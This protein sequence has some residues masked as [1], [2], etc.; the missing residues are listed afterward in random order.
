MLKEEAKTFLKEDYIYMD[1]ILDHESFVSNEIAF[2]GSSEQSVELDYIL[3]D[4]LPDIFRILKCSFYPKVISHSLNGE[5]LIFDLTLCIKILYLSNDSTCIN[6]IEQKQNYTK[7]VDLSCTPESP[8]FKITPC[9]DYVNCRVVNSRR[10]DIRGAVTTKIILESEKSTDIISSAKGLNVQ[11]KKEFVTF[12][13]KRLT[14]A[15]RITITEEIEL[16][17]TKGKINSVIK[18]DC[19]INSFDKK[20][21]AN[22]MIIK[23]EA[24]ISLLYNCEI[25]NDE[26]QN[27]ETVKFSVPFSQI[28]DIDGITEQY[29]AMTNISIASLD[30]IPNKSSDASEIE[31]EIIL[32]INCIAFRYDTLEL[33][34]DAYSTKYLCDFD[35]SDIKLEKKPIEIKE[36]QTIKAELMC[37]DSEISSAIDSWAKSYNIQSKYNTEKHTFSV[38]GNIE[39][40]AVAKNENGC[41]LYLE[42]TISFEHCL[43]INVDENSSAELNVYIDNCTFTIAS[44]DTIEIK[45]ELF[46]CGYVKE[47][48]SRKLITKINVNEDSIKSK[49]NCYAVKLYYAEQNEDIWEI[50]KKFSTSVSA[51]AQENE[52]SDSTRLQR[53]MLLIPILD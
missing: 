2:D 47:L 9:T 34:T 25:V 48:D 13:A 24:K 36:N 50:A 3:P 53:G 38:F 14:A 8:C 46:I 6:C 19:I 12:P 29:E 44:S 7:T 28:I 21:I 31:C 35:C 43:D 27:I 22:K 40:G 42:D 32:L 41:P 49:E 51:I 11:L 52:L 26:P 1:L 16:S 20:I 17:K 39:I 15:K 10:L 23:G 18:S 30:L 5:K 33:A 37:N 4:Y 45:A